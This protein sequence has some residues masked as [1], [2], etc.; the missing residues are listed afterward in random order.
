MIKCK[1]TGVWKSMVTTYRRMG[2]SEEEIAKRI[3]YKTQKIIESKAKE[4]GECDR[5]KHN[6]RS[7]EK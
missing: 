6:L 5:I 3:E 7:K 2:L 4:L 1:H